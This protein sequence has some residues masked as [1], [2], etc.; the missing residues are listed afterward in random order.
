MMAVERTKYAEL[1][2]TLRQLFHRGELKS[3]SCF[4]LEEEL[5][6]NRWSDNSEIGEKIFVGVPSKGIGV[7]DPSQ[8]IWFD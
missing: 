1:I 4:K 5:I 2:C 8:A 3:K 7:F 6:E